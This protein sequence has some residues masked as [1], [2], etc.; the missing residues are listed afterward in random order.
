MY[1]KRALDLKYLLKHKSLLLFGPRATGKT[2]LIHEELEDA[3]IFDLL[4][5]ETLQNLNVNPK[6]LSQVSASLD[7]STTIVIDE[8]QLNPGL[9]NEVHRI[10]NSNPE[11]R[12]LLTGSSARKLRRGG[13]NLLAGRAWQTSLFPLTSREIPDFDLLRYLN[14][15]GLPA[16]YFSEM[17]TKD[18]KN[19][20][21]TYLKE[22]IMAES[23]TRNLPA[24]NSFLQTVAISNGEELNYNSL[25][26]DCGV[27]AS[28]VKNYFQILDDTLIGFSLPSFKTVRRKSIS[29]S[30][31]YLFDIGVTNSLA[32]RSEIIEK[33][34][35]FGKAFEHFIILEVRAWNT[36][37]D[38]DHKLT[39][40]RST[41]KSEV[42]L[43]IGKELALEIK[44]TSSAQNK[45]LRHLR[46]LKD[47]GLIK[48]YALVSNDR[49]T[50]KTED[51]IMLYYWKDFIEQLYK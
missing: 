23:L 51:G 3:Y 36:Y 1:V 11:R 26:S 30:K 12:F 31:H 42:D 9:L 33:S 29:R 4:D 14:T 8:I 21:G 24:F 7:A 22:E 38:K 16:V 6:I 2:R 45:H 28:T 25:S 18:L 37:S 27:K 49:D 44:S 48:K 19:Y 15:G 17:P 46:A 41:S 10:H 50:R 43:I 13:A 39:Y 40:W 34:E 5:F 47:E 20:V 32:N 35:L